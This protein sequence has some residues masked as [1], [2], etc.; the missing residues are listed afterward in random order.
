MGRSNSTAD[1]HQVW[2]RPH[3]LAVMADTLHTSY[4]ASGDA[5]S[6]ELP[7]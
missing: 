2:G 6:K 7:I 1:R 5:K 3:Y 4:G